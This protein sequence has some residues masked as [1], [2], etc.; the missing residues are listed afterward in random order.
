MATML[1]EELI[2]GKPVERLRHHASRIVAAGLGA[3]DPRRAIRRVVRRRGELLSVGEAVYDL[4]EINQILVVGGG[5]AGAPM[6][7][8]LEDVL[9]SRITRGLVNVKYGYTKPLR[10]IE[11]IE[12]GHPLPDAAGQLGA[13][14]ILQIASEAGEDDLVVCL[15]SGGGSALL[16]APA[17]GIT[18]DEKVRTTD[19]LLKSGATITEINTVRKHLSRIKGG[20]LARAAAPSRVVVLVLSD[21]I[22]DRLD[23]IASGPA[24]ADPS[25]YAEALAIVDRYALTSRIPEGVLSHLRS[26]DAGVIAETPKP[27]DPLFTRVHAVVIGNGTLAARAAEREAKKLGFRTMLV[28]TA[29]EGE[30]R[31]TARVMAAIARSSLLAQIPLKLP[32]CILASGETTVTVHGTGKGGRCQEFVLAAALAVGG[33]PNTVVVGFGTDGTDGP[34]DAAGAF[35][36]GTTVA[37]ARGLGLDPLRS[38]EANDAYPFFSALTDLIFTGPTN[39]NVN[40]LYLVL[41]GDNGRT[42]RGKGLSVARVG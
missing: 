24:S 42:A 33:W 25:T 36:D 16:P 23:G 9:G 38:L 31:E 5:K 35:A 11:L 28:T 32:A 14:A 41:V 26:G 20:Q 8:G 7:A 22:G 39:T 3:A 40:D 17:S 19:L 13:E 34:T 18:L 15:L 12:A 21:V 1:N 27:G 37:R 29:L 6:A 2:V 30:A 10:R 4:R